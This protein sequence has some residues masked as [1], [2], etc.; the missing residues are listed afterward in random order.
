MESGQSSNSLERE[1][2]IC[3]LACKIL[4]KCDESGSESLMELPT[5]PLG[6][7]WTTCFNKQAGE[8]FSPQELSASQSQS[9]EHSCQVRWVWPWKLDVISTDRAILDRQ[10]VWLWH[11]M[12]KM[13]MH[14]NMLMREP[15]RFHSM[16]TEV[17]SFALACFVVLTS[18][19]TTI[20]FKEVRDHSVKASKGHVQRGKRLE[21]PPNCPFYLSDLVHEIWF[22]NPVKEP[23]FDCVCTELRHIKEFLLAGYIVSSV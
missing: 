5:L 7:V 8:L 1:L 23:N 17:Y 16:K 12:V 21:L 18:E 15:E 6:N 10:G 19:S 22:G 14:L 20:P 3:S 11:V 2:S 4:V 9:T 13:D